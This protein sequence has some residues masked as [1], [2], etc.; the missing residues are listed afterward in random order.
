MPPCMH[1]TM[2]AMLVRG[3]SFLYMRYVFLTLHVILV[4]G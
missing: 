3:M 1:A 4:M 2:H